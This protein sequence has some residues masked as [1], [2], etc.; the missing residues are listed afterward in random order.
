MMTEGLLEMIR[1]HE[2]LRLKPY[3]CPGGHATIGFGWN[4]DAH[5]LPDD[6]AACL[7]VNG[8]ITQDMAERLLNI[9]VDMATRQARAIYPGFDDFSERRRYALVDFVFNLG[10]GGALKF[11]KM[12]AAIADGDWDRAADCMIQ[13]KW[14]RQVG[15][16]SREIVGLIREG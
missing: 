3:I 12:R 15:N 9:S 2:G 13:S 7:R 6:I 14:F 8:A 10:V 4:M 5:P 1:R 16:R 11:K